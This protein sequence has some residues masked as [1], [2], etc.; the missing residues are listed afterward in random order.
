MVK[1]CHQCGTQVRVEAQFC[2]QC[3]AVQPAAAPVAQ[4]SSTMRPRLLAA[5]AAV[6]VVLF[7]GASGVWLILRRADTGPNTASQ[8]PPA[9][10]TPDAMEAAT[11]APAT[12][13]AVA[14]TASMTPTP[15]ASATPPPLTATS[16]A[17]P[18]PLPSATPAPTATPAWSTT[19]D[20]VAN[21]VAVPPTIDGV[22]DEWAAFS[23]IASA[24]QVFAGAG[25]DGTADLSAGWRLA[26][27]QAY[28][29]VAVDV[30]DDIHVQTESGDQVYRGDSVELQLDTDLAGDRDD[31]RLS[32]DDYQIALSPG[33]FAALPPSAVRVRGSADGAQLPAPG[34]SVR[35]AARATESGYTLEAAIP[36]ADLG[37]APFRGLVIGLALNASDNDGPG[38]AVQEVLISNV[39]TRTYANPT[40]WGRLTLGGP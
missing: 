29:Y 32:A 35:V 31:R 37:L 5:T 14:P 10:E 13:A 18:T 28:L 22:L 26:W 25:W 1:Y 21:E 36:W 15:T 4:P 27:D 23:G 11:R 12:V 40:T 38:T 24:F 17:T 19:S 34:H 8:T 3:G 39:D 16:T 33:D 6:L 2:P 30:S 7:F 20:V 9:G